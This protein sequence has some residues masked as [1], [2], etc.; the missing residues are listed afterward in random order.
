MYGGEI[1][2]NTTVQGGGGVSLF[3]EGT[4]IM[5]GGIISNNT[6]WQAGGVFVQTNGAFIMYGGEISD[7]T[8]NQRR[9]RRSGSKWTLH[10]ERRRNK[11]K[12]CRVWRRS[13]YRYFRNC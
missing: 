2:D 12:Y 1:S 11:Q 7:N 5:N 6:A 4:F 3:S 13:S 8:S 10:N 9:R